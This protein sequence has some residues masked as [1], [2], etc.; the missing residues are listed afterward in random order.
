M[1][2]VYPI[3]TLL[4]LETKNYC[5]FGHDGLRNESMAWAIFDSKGHRKY[6]NRCEIQSFLQAA[7]REPREVHAFCWLLAETGCRISE[8]LALDHTRID[9]S[10][11]FIIFECLK[12]RRRGVFRTVPIS[13]DLIQL[14]E[15]IPVFKRGAPIWKWSRMTAY[16]RVRD[17]MDRV[18][19]RGPQA[20]PKGLRHGF[21]MAAVDVG[22]PLN[23]I[24]RWLGH[25]DIRTTSIYTDA[26]GRE[27]IALAR[28]LWQKN[29]APNVRMEEMIESPVPTPI[30]GDRRI[31]P[32]GDRRSNDRYGPVQKSL[33]SI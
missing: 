16:R 6:L 20:T 18:P 32:N 24:Q 8:A 7:E 23:I 2:I 13:A 12:K 31:N 26:S 5:C 1:D 9:A 30:Y 11:G 29:G 19:I 22:V 10:A 17:V 4:L 33:V 3:K 14:I 28:R 27:E 15:S 25:A 21:A